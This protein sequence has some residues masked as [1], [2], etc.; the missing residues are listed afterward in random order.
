MPEIISLHADDKVNTFK[1]HL[2]GFLGLKEAERERQRERQRERGRDAT[3]SI[4][5]PLPRNPYPHFCGVRWRAGGGEAGERERRREPREGRARGGMGSSRGGGLLGR[6]EG[7][8]RFATKL[9]SYKVNHFPVRSGSPGRGRGVGRGAGGFS[10]EPAG[11][12]PPSRRG[13][14]AP[15]LPTASGPHLASQRRAPV[16]TKGARESGDEPWGSTVGL[17]VCQSVCLFCRRQKDTSAPRPLSPYPRE[18]P[19][20]R[21]RR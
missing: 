13:L 20:G 2:S 10:P 1:F 5:F 8:R 19:S 11:A 4:S 7:E 9:R 17:R 12:A 18:N 3:Q 6:K 16:A 14:P 15:R 21:R